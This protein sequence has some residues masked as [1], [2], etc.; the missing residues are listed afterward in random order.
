MTPDDF[1]RF[2]VDIFSRPI[3]NGDGFKKTVLCDHEGSVN[4]MEILGIVLYQD[5]E[6]R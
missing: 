1:N 6:V 4:E 3:F 2:D 5:D